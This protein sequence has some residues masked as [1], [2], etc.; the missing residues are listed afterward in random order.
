MVRAQLFA[1]R[2]LAAGLIAPATGGAPGR[3][4]FVVGAGAAGAT[5]AMLA[6]AKNV[7][8]FLLD[9]QPSPFSRQSVC[10]SRWVDPSQYDWP[11]RT[12]AVPRYPQRPPAAP[13]AWAGARA[14]R[15]A[16]D[17]QRLL[18]AAIASSAGLIDP[19]YGRTLVAITPRNN[20]LRIVHGDLGVPAANLAHADVGALVSAIGFGTER[21]DVGPHFRS[22]SFWET[23]DLEKPNLGLPLPC[24]RVVISGAGDGALQDFIR[25]VTGWRSARDV[26]AVLRPSLPPEVPEAAQY[27]EQEA[28]RSYVW[29]VDAERD[30]HHVLQ[31]LHDEY[32]QLAT[33]VFGRL[34]PRIKALIRTR[35]VRLAYSCSHFGKVYGLNR[36]IALLL[37]K[38]LEDEDDAGLM[39]GRRLSAVAS[40]D[41]SHTCR[42]DPNRCHGRLHH[43]TFNPHP[44]CR[45]PFD[46]VSWSF[47]DAETVIVRHGIAPPQYVY[48]GAPTGAPR[49][50][51]PY[52]V[53]Q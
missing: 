43:L 1:Q 48:G 38:G 50:L 36:L 3:P 44:D 31:R 40:G 46:G 47:E 8:T 11:H 32:D 5:L 20:Q 29:G 37:A 14:S 22:W 4:L 25:A 9:Q 35:T 28:E 49:Q 16:N 42:R 30:D 41:P 34:A 27:F 45:L 10:R 51:L 53:A 33:R 19:L 2:A 13:L 17:W 52:H 7:Q 21:C 18:S 23:D 15:L 6:A 39:P 26:Y 12:W 24:P